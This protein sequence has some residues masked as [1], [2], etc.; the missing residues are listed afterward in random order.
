MG[1]PL[2]TFPAR[3]PAFR[4]G[5]DPKRR[6]SSVVV[7]QRVEGVGQRDHRADGETAVFHRH[8]PQLRHLAHGDQVTERP[9]VLRHP[10]PQVGPP[11]QEPGPR[12]ALAER[13]QLGHRP[14]SVERPRG[15]SQH[16]A[17]ATSD[18]PEP[19]GQGRLARRRRP[20]GR[21]RRG[22]EPVLLRGRDRPAEGVHRPGRVDDRAVPRAAAEVAGEGV[23]DRLPVRGWLALVEREQRHHEARR[24]EAALRPVAL[25]ERPLD[26]V[27]SGRGPVSGTLGEALDGQEGSPVQGRQELDAGVHRAVPELRT[28]QLGQDDGAGAAVALGA[29]LLRPRAAEVLAQVL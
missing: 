27:E 29:T 13:R 23:G 8:L 2:A 3:V 10:E 18:G 6:K 15:V 28:V 4:M 12:P 24:A 1:E 7:R 11:R 16:E 5:G 26:G 19:P 21:A 17:S 14:G 20:G 25:G 22:A 9:I